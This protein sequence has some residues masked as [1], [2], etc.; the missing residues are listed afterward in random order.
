MDIEINKNITIEEYKVNPSLKIVTVQELNKYLLLDNN[1]ISLLGFFNKKT[2][3]EEL[4]N[5]YIDSEKEVSIESLKEIVIKLAQMGVLNIKGIKR[6]ENK[7]YIKIKFHLISGP[8]VNLI[9]KKI[10]FLHANI[11]RYFVFLTLPF[12]LFYVFYFFL[13]YYKSSLFLTE[14][15]RFNHILIIITCSYVSILFHEFGHASALAYYEKKPGGIGVGLYLYFIP[16][17]FAD[18][19][20]AWKLDTG[21]RFRVNIS[22][23]YFQYLFVLIA[24]LVLY[25]TVS[26]LVAWFLF[27]TGLI[28]MISQFNPLIRLD[29]Y[30]IISDLLKIEDLMSYGNR[31]LKKMYQ[32]LF[33]RRKN[34]FSKIEKFVLCYRA[35]SYVFIIFMI[36]VLINTYSGIYKNYLQNWQNLI[37]VFKNLHLDL[38]L[39]EIPQLILPKLIPVIVATTSSLFI[40]YILSKLFLSLLKKILK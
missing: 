37:L 33:L 10:N 6:K 36:V 12:T 19:S 32:T 3:L 20:E 31:T 34:Q 39:N 8:F 1:T 5:K 13:E 29:G 11:I 24:T 15:T 40:V 9:C 25:F 21:Q 16:V 17:F 38:P 30:W 18:V 22:G 2:T 23:I 28:S 14:I 26:N 4:Y 35:G 27:F 7:K